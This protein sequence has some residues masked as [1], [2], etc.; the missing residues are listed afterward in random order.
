[1]FLFGFG[2]AFVA[3][4]QQKDHQSLHVEVQKSRTTFHNVYL[5]A[6]CQLELL[7]ILESIA[8]LSGPC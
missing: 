6:C 8:E 7:I 1:M 4:A 3:K 2:M 5:F